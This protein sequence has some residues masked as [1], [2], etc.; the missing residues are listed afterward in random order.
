ME[1]KLEVKRIF[2]ASVEEVWKMWTEPEYVKQWW[3]PDH[4]ICPLANI[5][6]N[7]GSTSLICMQAPKEF[8]GQVHYNIWQYTKIIHLKRIEFVMNLADENGNKQKPSEVGM[9]ADFPEDIRTVV[10]F[11]VINP[12]ETEMTVTEYAN[13][14]Q[15]THFATLGLEQSLDKAVML[16]ISK[17]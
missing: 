4:F 14:G 7:E 6:F 2:N 13:F 5:N 15:I 10:T 9:P 16:F 17:K 3:G 12:A 11:N 1:K 8:G